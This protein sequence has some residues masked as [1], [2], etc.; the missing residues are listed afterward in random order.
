MASPSRSSSLTLAP[1]QAT[2]AGKASSLNI[3]RHPNLTPPTTPG[4]S[5]TPTSGRGASD[6]GMK[7]KKEMCNIYYFFVSSVFLIEGENEERQEE[8]IYSNG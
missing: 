8:V 2:T 3:V 5:H 4:A 7:R 1:S 6:V